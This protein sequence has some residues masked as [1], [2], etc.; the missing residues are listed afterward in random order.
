[1]VANLMIK[2]LNILSAK[3]GCKATIVIYC[4]RIQKV[5]SI[6]KCEPNPCNAFNQEIK[7]LKKSVALNPMEPIATTYNKVVK[8]L[9]SSK[10]NFG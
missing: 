1:M 3:K 5:S 8:N 9:A 4:D 10:F 6:Q 7:N 2:M